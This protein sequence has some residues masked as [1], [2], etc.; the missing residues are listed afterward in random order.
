[1]A[2]TF[3]VTVPG[4]DPQTIT[5]DQPRVVIGRGAHVDVRLPSRAVSDQ[6]AMVRV[7]GPDVSIIDEGSTN[8]TRVNGV[9]IARGRRKFLRD[10][11]EIGVG[12][13]AIKVSFVIALADP[14]ERTA[15]LARRLLKD[16]LRSLGGDSAPP[17]LELRSGKT[18][19][20]RW[21]IPAAG[22]R[23]TLGRAE[24]CEVLLDDRDCS[25]QHAEVER[26]AEGFLLRDLGSRNGIVVGGRSLTEKRLKNGDEF[27]IGKSALRFV[28]PT[29]ELLRGFES[30]ADE[31]APPPPPRPSMPPP[32]PSI[33]PPPAEPAGALAAATVAPDAKALKE[34]KGDADWIVLA[35][36]VVILVVSVAALVIVLKG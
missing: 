20:R 13:Y 36:A 25:R 33:P 5:L 6:H 1:V 23:L 10:G 31:A 7:D 14:P 17:Y 2:L 19:G 15:T 29:E 30:G 34:R 16:S 26:D 22:S 35:L 3:L 21:E 32:T 9:A 18:A 4:S 8:G 28:D 24:G 27:T 12:D 11:D